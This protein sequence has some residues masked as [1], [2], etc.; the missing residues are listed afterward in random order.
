LVAITK[1]NM[2]KSCIITIYDVNLQSKIHCIASMCQNIWQPF[3]HILKLLMHGLF[4][5][6]KICCQNKLES[7]KYFIKCLSNKK[8]IFY[9]SSIHYHFFFTIFDSLISHLFEMF[10]NVFYQSD[11]FSHALRRLS[12][13]IRIALSSDV[14][15]IVRVQISSS[16]T[17]TRC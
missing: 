13:F 8:S 12:S 2:H 10:A 15:A 6:K 1:N 7:Q 5:N 3:R 4:K 14:K 11:I 17:Q 9:V 16:S